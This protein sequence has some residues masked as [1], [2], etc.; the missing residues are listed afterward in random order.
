M[1]GIAGLLGACSQTTRVGDETNA[2]QLAQSGKAVAVM[3]LG[4]ASPHCQHVGVWLGVREGPGFR[5]TKPVAVIHATSLLDVPVAEVELDP[6]EYHVVSY[7]CS[8]GAKVSQ[9]ATYDRT[10]GLTRTSHA[11]FSIAAGEVV[12]VGSFEFHAARHGT[13]AFGRELKTTVTVT[14]W[15]LADLDKYKAKRPQIYAQMK[16]RLMSVTPR[17]GQ[18]AGEDE[19]GRIRKLVAEGK[20]QNLPTVCTAGAEAKTAAKAR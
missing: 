10:T 7:A 1:A 4:M 2:G 9:V 16:T 12:N 17:S 19:C 5:P 18:D 14:D 6:G 13:N 20:L 11:S 15:P 3:R 8:T